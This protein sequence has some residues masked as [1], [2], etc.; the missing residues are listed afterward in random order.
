MRVGARSLAGRGFALVVVLW[1][2]AG[3]AVVAAAVAATVHSNA[4]SVKLLRE[5]VAAEAAFL[6]T[7]GR[8]K[9]LAVTGQPRP[10]Y[11]IGERGALYLD[12][13]PTRV[14]AQESVVLQDGLGL[15][16]LNQPQAF[17]FSNLLLQCGANERELP[18]LIDA[19]ADYVDGDSLKR[20][21]GA[22]A[23]EYRA[24]Q[25]AP[26]RNAEL[27]SREELWRVKGWSSIR[28]AWKTNGC[29]EL[30][31]VQGR[32]GF[33]RN[34]APPALLVA[35]GMTLAQAD[36]LM[37]ARNAGLPATGPATT[38]PAAQAGESSPF[39]IIAGSVVGE[40]FRVRHEMPW[41]E[42]ALQYELELSPTEPGGPWRVHEV[43]VV[44]P[45]KP[46]VA[47]WAELPAVDFLLP[48][49]ERAKLNAL[50]SSPFGQ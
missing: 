18:S 19:L 41:L 11:R 38:T 43:R 50:P 24:A 44:P 48:E 42:W 21:N 25:L 30:V 27:L 8:I 6:S 1:V 33:N 17:L 13:R 28:P 37:D 7:S 22:E 9:I 34:T 20:L 47:V 45:G 29:D 10:A 12:G 14:S 46:S 40:V 35:A 32:S 31:T 15:L 2:L 36:A 26:P 5:R 49:R 4:Q 16:N 3:L 39:G 23:P